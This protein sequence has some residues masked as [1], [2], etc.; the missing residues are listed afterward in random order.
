[1]VTVVALTTC[2]SVLLT[3]GVVAV[4]RP[5]GG[6]GGGRGSS[7]MS[8]G[9]FASMA[10]TAA[11][12][13][14]LRPA[15]AK[16]RAISADGAERWGSG[17]IFRADGMML[18]TSHTVE[19]AD[20]LQVVLDDGRQVEGRLVGTDRDTDIAVIDLDGDQFR[21]AELASGRRTMKLG[22]PA[23]TI[24]VHPGPDASGP[25]VRVTMV[26][27]MGQEA[28]TGG[29]TYV[30]MI[31]MDG[32]VAPGCEGGAIV[33]GN[34][35]VVA[36]ASANTSEGEEAI[37]Y[38]TPI[39][40]A[41]AVAT[42]LLADGKVRRGWIGIE[43]ATG[44]DGVV[45]GNVLPDGPAAAAGIVAGD[46]IKAFHGSEVTSMTALVVQLRALKPGTATTVVVER[47]SR[48]LTMPLELGQRPD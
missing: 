8:D 26:S 39:D 19:G 46:V 33:D 31:R 23:M 16:I 28:R 5:F 38:A 37:G 42:Q 21:T 36:I 13:A 40:V 43:G 35:R 30:D 3:L 27:A 10:D 34:G 32:P 15:I 22:Q 17:V 7:V 45:V 1:M 44:D 4:I 29:R 47:N 2:I 20:G 11:V 41:T 14:R 9:R 24:G 12:T 48:R 25:V 6:G 18:T